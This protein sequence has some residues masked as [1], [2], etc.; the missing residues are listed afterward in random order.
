[1]NVAI[2]FI[3]TGKYFQFFS[4]FHSSLVK[5]FMPEA[6]RHFYVFTDFP[7]AYSADDVTVVATKHEPWPFAT[8]NRFKY[9]NNIGHLLADHDLVIYIDADMKAI[10]LV[11]ETEFIKDLNGKS[12]FAVQHPGFYNKRGT[13]ET[14]PASTACISDGDDLSFY[15]QGCFWGG[16]PQEVL[17]MCKELQRRIE[18][19][20]RNEV[21]A[22]WHDESHM[23]K[24][25]AENREKST[26]LDPG[27]AFSELYANLPHK[28]RLQHL[29]KDN[30][31]LHV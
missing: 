16:S 11:T 9:I 5:L 17:F 1:M 18:D 19:D 30:T 6:N 4:E 21:I 27:Y 14:N 8:L 29:T 15:L 13:F 24:Y 23:N 12:L 26:S 3:G 10:D 20:L 2:V 7:H 25:F 22:V 31:E 28:K